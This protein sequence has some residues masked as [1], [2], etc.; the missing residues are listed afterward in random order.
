MSGVRFQRAVKSRSCFAMGGFD[1]MPVVIE[2]MSVVIRADALLAAFDNDWA[3][4]KQTVLNSTFCADGDLVRVG[5][6]A[7]Q[8]ADEYIQLLESAGLRFLVD[9]SPKDI[10]VVDQFLGPSCACDWIELVDISLDRRRLKRVKACQAK[11]STSNELATPEGWGFRS[12]ESLR[13]PSY[14]FVP[15]DA[16]DDALVFLRSEDGTDVYGIEP[17][18]KEIYVPRSNGKKPRWQFRT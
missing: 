9:G 14:G 1:E 8:D 4:F 13:S 3:R 15:S 7:P 11:G 6:M 2:A 5:F 12:L 10:V 17:S 18:V 16:I